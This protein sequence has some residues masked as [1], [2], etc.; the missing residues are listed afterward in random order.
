MGWLIG[1]PLFALIRWAEWC[2]RFWE[3][4]DAKPWHFW[5]ALVA[6][7]GCIVVLFWAWVTQPA[8]ID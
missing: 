1:I 4:V 5:F 3:W 7:V 6:V 2:G 8:K